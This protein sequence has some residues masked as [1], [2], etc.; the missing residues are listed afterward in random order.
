[1]L[2]APGRDAKLA[3]EGISHKDDSG[4]SQKLFMPAKEKQ[5]S[6]VPLSVVVFKTNNPQKHYPAL[7]SNHQISKTKNHCKN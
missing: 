4:T 5:K 3:G 6:Q 7:G 1:M 2:R